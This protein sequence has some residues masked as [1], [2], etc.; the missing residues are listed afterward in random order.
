MILNIWGRRCYLINN[1]F[2]SNDFEMMVTFKMLGLL[3]IRRVKRVR[4]TQMALKMLIMVHDSW[5]HSHF[6]MITATM[7]IVM[8]SVICWLALDQCSWPQGQAYSGLCRGP[9]VRYVPG[10]IK[11]WM[12]KGISGECNMAYLIG[13]T[14]ENLSVV[15]VEQV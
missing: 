6:T 13:F 7:L 14:F 11:W 1:H 8:V 9:G 12:V 15:V 10:Q 2:F 3:T 5:R 4:L